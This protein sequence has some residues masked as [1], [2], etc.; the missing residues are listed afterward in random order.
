LRYCVTKRNVAAAISNGVIG[1]FLWYNASGRTMV[2]GSANRNENQE[3]FLA[4]KGDRLSLNLGNQ[5][6]QK[7]FQKE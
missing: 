7:V 2:L 5:E 1:I 6:I 3:Y 4:G